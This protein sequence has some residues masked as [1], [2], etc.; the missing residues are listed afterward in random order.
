M[1]AGRLTGR[2]KSQ[3][4]T[5]KLAIKISKRNSTQAWNTNYLVEESRVRKWI[6]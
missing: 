1:W 4:K 5:L 6:I 3:I 2:L